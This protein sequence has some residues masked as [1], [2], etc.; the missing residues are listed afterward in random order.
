MTEERRKRRDGVYCRKNNIAA[1][2]LKK[3]H[4]DAP[5]R[6][7]LVSGAGTTTGDLRG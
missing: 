3:N 1:L 7:S 6:R 5:S 4:C 2:L